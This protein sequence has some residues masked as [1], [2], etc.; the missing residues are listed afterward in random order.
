MEKEVL[1]LPQTDFHLLSREQL[2]HLV[3]D[4]GKTDAEIAQMFGISTNTVHH[5]RRQMNLLEGQMT[6]E[7]LAEVVRL[8]EQVK[9]LPKE[10]VAEVRAIVERY[11]H[12][13]W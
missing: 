6:S 5:R 12:P 2:R 1:S 11:Q 7:E 10:A 8:A 3:F 4:L 13:T 9:H